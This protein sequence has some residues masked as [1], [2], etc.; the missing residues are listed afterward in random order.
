MAIAK[1]KRRTKGKREAKINWGGAA[2]ANSGAINFVLGVLTL[3]VLAAGAAYWWMGRATEGDFMTL[4]AQGQ[5]ALARV[6]SFPNDGR[7]HLS[8]GESH[9]YGTSTPTSGA[10]D[11]SPT[12]PGVYDT[13]QPPTKLVHALEHGLIVLYYD[14]PRPDVMARLR[15]W[16]GLYS[17]K[18]DGIVVTPL[19]G[20]GETVIAT[21]WRKKLNLAPFDAAA[22]A[23]FIDAYRGRGPENPVR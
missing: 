15:D 23:A 9:S 16:A 2:A 7:S 8:P 1:T 5:A 19:S 10:H 21:A 18:W 11:P 4:A 3:A 20:L 22:A 17:G 14:K 13:P 6:E 12:A